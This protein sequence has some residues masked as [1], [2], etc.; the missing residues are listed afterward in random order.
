MLRFVSSPET[1]TVEEI[2]AYTPSG[3]GTHLYLWIEKR[4]LTTLDAIGR[5]AS[6]LRVEA[7][8]VGYA[9]MKDR[10]AVTRQWISVPD[11]APELALQVPAA[12]DC[13]ILQAVRH[14]NKL[15]LGHLRGNRFEML[16]QQA[17]GT[18]DPE[19]DLAGVQGAL[20]RIAAEGVA[21]R[22]GAQR[23]GAGGDNAAAGLAVL[24]GQRREHDRRRRRLLL[25][26]LQSAVFNDCLQ[27]R[28]ATGP[29]LRVREGDVLQKTDTG[30][31]FVTPD[32]AAD[33]A[34]VDRG[35]VV[36]TGPLPG[37]REIEPPPGSAARALEDQAIAATGATR[38]EFEQAGR[39]LPGARR[40]VVI[41]PQDLAAHAEA[42]GVRVSFALPAGA[43]ATVVVDAILA[44]AAPAPL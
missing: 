11:V 23:F 32:P 42:G 26:A 4:D 43:Y 28:A 29:L 8:D 44:G 14:T 16:L 15:R 12:P 5:V 7:R 34:R 30:G 13:A 36:P 38:E 40:A 1:F 27:R 6:A 20:A 19:A 31:L 3:Q 22:F 35:E 37:G 21:N 39:H 24:R 9:G 2:P 10:H 18:S 25:S 17:P 41:R 33:Q